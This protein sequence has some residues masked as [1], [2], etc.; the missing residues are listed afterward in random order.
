MKTNKNNWSVEVQ[1]I[2]RKALDNLDP[3]IFMN[4]NRAFMKHIEMRGG[5]WISIQDA[6]NNEWIIRRDNGDP[7]VFKSLDD[8]IESGWVLD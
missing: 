4:K 6:L 2:T 7:L 3:C 8:L 5:G 1:K